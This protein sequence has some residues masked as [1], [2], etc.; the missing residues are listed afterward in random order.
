MAIEYTIERSGDVVIVEARGFDEGLEEVL[1]Y[2]RAIKERAEALGCK[3][4]LSIE[5]ELEYRLS[6]V[7]TYELAEQ[8]SDMARGFKKIAIVT[9]EDNQDA[10]Q[11]WEDV[12]TNRGIVVRVFYRLEE[13]EEWL[14]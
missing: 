4:I 14:S 3:K 9:G 12:A 13:A 6:I 11:F 1:D 8:L 10:A 5:S 2:N 7:E